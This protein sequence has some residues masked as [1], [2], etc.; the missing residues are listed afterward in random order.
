VTR[1]FLHHHESQHP[2]C[3][4]TRGNWC[5]RFQEQVPVPTKPVPRGS[6]D[7]PNACSGWGNCNHDTGLCECPAGHGGLDCG[8]PLKRPCTNRF[9]LLNETNSQPISHIGPDN[10]DL[11]PR[12]SGWTAGRCHGFCDDDNSMCY[13]GGD[14]ALRRIPAPVGSAPWAPPLQHGRPMIIDCKPST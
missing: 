12:A 6:K 11:D 14:S 7:C 5:S 13:C 10:N 8:E 4:V 9:R 1:E 3:A 2:R